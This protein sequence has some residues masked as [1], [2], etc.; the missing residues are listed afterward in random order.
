M[1]VAQSLREQHGFRG[2]IHLKTIPGASESLIEQAEMARLSRVLVALKEDCPLPMSLDAF[3]LGAIPPDPLAAFLQE[4]GFN[5]LL[6]R[7]GEYLRKR[8]VSLRGADFQDD[9]KALE[10]LRRMSAAAKGGLFDQAVRVR[11][12]GAI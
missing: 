9:K 7:L 5:S 6:K 3:E 1:R 11:F 8:T 2:Y 10:E 12:R 4:H